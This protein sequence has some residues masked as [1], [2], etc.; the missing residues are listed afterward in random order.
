MPNELTVT[1]NREVG[2]FN[3]LDTFENAQRMANMLSKSDLVPSFYRGRPEN[4][5]IAMEMA[6][7]L[8]I[9]PLMVMQNLHTI[10]GKPSWSG[11]FSSAAISASGRFSALRYIRED[12]GEVEITYQ[13][14]QW[15]NKVKSYATKTAKIRNIVVRAWATEVST[16]EKLVGPEVSVE[17]AY[18]EGWA[19]KNG[20]KWTTMPE[21]MLHYRAATFFAR[22]YDPAALLGMHTEDEVIDANFN[23]VD[24]EKA[25]NA[26]TVQVLTPVEQ[27]KKTRVRK[28]KEPE[29]KTE[30][31]ISETSEPIIPECVQP[32]SEQESVVD[33]E[34]V[35]EEETSSGEIPEAPVNLNN[36]LTPAAVDA[37]IDD[38]F[39]VWG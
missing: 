17:M 20:S 12:K 31:P 14:A 36:T 37:A 5:M 28:P 22:I 26:E 6:Q 13:V 9:S 39:E 24:A 19:T 7:R 8:R 21:L 30:S 29:V 2:V 11:Q 4:C 18:K 34:E 3:N 27:P 23:I 1:N 10:E 38:D 16:G 33:Y 32:Q 15:D 35:E 25:E